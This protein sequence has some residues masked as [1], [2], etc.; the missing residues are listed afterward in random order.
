[1]KKSGSPVP[2]YQL[3]FLQAYLFQVF[4]LENKC[5]KNFN[6]TRWFFEGT[7]S[8]G[9]VNS[10]IAFLKSKG[11]KCDCDVIKKLD[12]KEFSKGIISS[13]D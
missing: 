11:L 9:E 10:I 3:A 6:N 2:I 7:Y 1:V 5:K 12:L 13:H 8:D 4:T